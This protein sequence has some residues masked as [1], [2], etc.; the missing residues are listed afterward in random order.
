MLEQKRRLDQL[1][2]GRAKVKNKLSTANS[3][4]KSQELKSREELQSL[5]QSLA[6]QT[7]KW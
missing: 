7:E 3:H 5:K 2:Q 6:Q 4:L 1:V